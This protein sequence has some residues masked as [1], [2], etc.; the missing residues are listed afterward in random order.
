MTKKELVSTGIRLGIGTKKELESFPVT[1]LREMIA[2][3]HEPLLRTEVLALDPERPAVP[4]PEPEKPKS[5]FI[6]VDDLIKQGVIKAAGD[7]DED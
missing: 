7:D 4:H 5:K 1:E 2:E 3:T 6:T